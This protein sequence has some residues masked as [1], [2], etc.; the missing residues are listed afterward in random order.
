MPPSDPAVGLFKRG[1]EIDQ[2]GGERARLAR[3][4]AAAGLLRLEERRFVRCVNPEDPDQRYLKNRDCAGRI[5][6][7]RGR[8]EDD[9]QYQCPAC[10]RTVFPSRKRESTSLRLTPVDHAVSA[11][12]AEQIEK[13]GLQPTERPRGVFRVACED[14][15][16]EVCLVDRCAVPAVFHPNYPGR[17]L[18][19]VGNDRDLLRRIPKGAEVFRLTELALGDVSGRFQRVLRALVRGTA[20][21]GPPMAAVFGLAPPFGSD[22][23][24]PAKPTREALAPAG[25]RWNQVALHYIDGDTLSVR[26]G[27]HRARQLTYRDLDMADGRGNKRTMR[28]DMLVALCEGGGHLEWRGPSR[29]KSAFKQR[30]SQL[31]A[32]LQTSFGIQ[33]NPLT[34]TAEDGLKSAFAAYPYAPGDRP[35]E[36]AIDLDNE[37]GSGIDWPR[38][39][40]RK[41][42]EQARTAATSRPAT[43]PARPPARRG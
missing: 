21:D 42:S 31:R 41:K 6:L 3:T 35:A 27:D 40:Q 24:A 5:Y 37:D 43:S 32:G 19:V 2:L 25:T 28:W 17:V 10:S 9:Y 16:A 18:F 26:I 8:D 15:E 13:A 39:G 1:L 38:T 22:E 23:T 29:E 34:L 11:F 30:V 14:G 33:G 12:V 20:G 7:E 4:L 36:D